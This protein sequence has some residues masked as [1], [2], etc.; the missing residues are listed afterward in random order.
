MVNSTCLKR[1]ATERVSATL[2]LDYTVV[3]VAHMELTNKAS[4]ILH[5]SW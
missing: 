3:S 4:R 2:H 5:R 1:L